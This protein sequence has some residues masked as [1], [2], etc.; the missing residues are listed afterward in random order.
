MTRPRITVAPNGARLQKSDHPA[1]PLSVDE[2]ASTAAACWASGADALHLHVR[3]A[4][5]KHSLDAGRYRAALDAIGE[6]APER[7][8]PDLHNAGRA[9]LDLP[10]PGALAHGERASHALERGGVATGLNKRRKIRRFY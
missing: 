7:G 5:G 1:V 6:L 3:D 10:V 2:I 8:P 4:Q 9:Y